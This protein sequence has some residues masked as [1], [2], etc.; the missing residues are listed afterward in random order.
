MD[1]FPKPFLQFLRLSRIVALALLEPLDW[2]HRRV[3]SAIERGPV[4]PLWVRRHSG[5]IWAFDRAAGEIAA[6]IAVLNLIQDDA[7]VLDVGCGCGS[8]AAEFQRMLGRSGTYVGFDVHGPS[9]R[10][11]KKRF[12]ADGRFRFALAELSTAW[13]N[14]RNA[15]VEYRFPMDDAGAD[16]VLAKSVFTHLLTRESGHYLRETRRVLRHGGAAL[17]TAFLVEDGVVAV[18]RDRP[19][20]LTFPYGDHP[21]WWRVKSRP[22]AAVAYEKAYFLGMVEAA[23]LRV[24]RL[25]PGSWSGRGLSPTLQD[26]IIVK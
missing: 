18:Q 6:T 7:S 11:C 10:W 13:S 15:V 9:I 24:E 8:M 12:A 17:L 3:T 26:L 4:P 23:N 21:V 20:E 5:P 1:R 19:A 25:I 16:L 14:G 2:V 22:E